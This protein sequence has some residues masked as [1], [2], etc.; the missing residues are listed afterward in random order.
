MSITLFK[1]AFSLKHLGKIAKVK[2]LKLLN[3]SLIWHLESKQ[4][5]MPRQSGFRQHRS[6]E[7]QV[8]YITQETEGGF[9]DQK[10]TLAVR[11][12]ME[13]AFDTV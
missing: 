5:L 10:H 6:T 13:K 9:Q 1:K 12:D 4:L 7:D 8:S 2:L 3:I 11:V